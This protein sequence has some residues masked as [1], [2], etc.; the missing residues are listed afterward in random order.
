M[1]LVFV[2]ALIN[3]GLGF[4]T[5]V[6]AGRGPWSRYARRPVTNPLPRA[7][8]KPRIDKSI[9]QITGELE[10]LEFRFEE[11]LERLTAEPTGQISSEEVRSIV[12]N[13][14][15]QIESLTAAESS[16]ERPEQASAGLRKLSLEVQ[17]ALTEL[18]RAIEKSGKVSKDPV[19]LVTCLL[20]ACREVRG[21]FNALMFAE[22]P[23]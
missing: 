19:S 14:G 15:T 12:G 4:A 17:T 3:V 5:A 7:I 10:G 20:M 8:P 22:L 2:V 18:D 11:L 9:E 23:N 6:Y 1:M 21:V 13:M 16:Q